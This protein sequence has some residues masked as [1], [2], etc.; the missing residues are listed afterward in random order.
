MTIDII[1]NDFLQQYS[2]HSPL[3]LKEIEKDVDVHISYYK[4]FIQ[5][6]LKYHFKCVIVHFHILFKLPRMIRTRNS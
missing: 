6:L 3:V 4:V 2:E 5:T 1:H